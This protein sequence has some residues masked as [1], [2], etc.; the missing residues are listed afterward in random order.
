MGF[1]VSRDELAAVFGRDR[2]VSVPVDVRGGLI[3]HNGTRRFLSGV[4]LPVVP[5][6]LYDPDG[7][8]ESGPLPVGSAEP[9]LDL[10]E[11]LPDSTAHWVVLGYCYSDVLYL[12]GSTGVLWSSAVGD[13]EVTVANSGLDCFASFLAAFAGEWDAFAEG[14]TLREREQA[15]ERLNVRFRTVD[16]PAL[17]DP[18]RMWPRVLDGL[19]HDYPA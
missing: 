1:A 15:A 4:G 10:L 8:L 16:A 11:N 14:T 9:E 7:V 5:G 6:F 13:T 17:A 12:D 2:L 18:D 3:V 19:I